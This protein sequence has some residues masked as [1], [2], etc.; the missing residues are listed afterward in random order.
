MLQR[1]LLFYC[2]SSQ[3]MTFRTPAKRAVLQITAQC[4]QNALDEMV[5]WR[6]TNFSNL[7]NQRWTS[8]I[9][10]SPFGWLNSHLDNGRKS[11]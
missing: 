4:Y 10:T 3:F 2:L 7:A 11:Q 9:G 5:K 8:L 6:R 1:A